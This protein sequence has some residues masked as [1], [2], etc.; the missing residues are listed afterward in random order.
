MVE[1]SL[2]FKR[3]NLLIRKPLT[4]GFIYLFLYNFLSAAQG[5]LLSEIFQKKS[6][7]SF[8]F[9]NFLLLSLL[10]WCVFVFKK[11]NDLR[12]IRL[13]DIGLLNII[14]VISW[15]SY[16]LALKYIEPAIEA[17][18]GCAIPAIVTFVILL[19][20]QPAA[21]QKREEVF[22]VIGLATGS[23]ILVIT[24]LSGKSGKVNGAGILVYLGL[25]MAFLCGTSVALYSLFSKKLS[26]R[27]ISANTILCL[28]F[29]LLLIIACWFSPTGEISDI[30]ISNELLVYS[31]L[32]ISGT[33]LPLYFLQLG[34]PKLEPLQVSFMMG[35]LPAFFFINQ[36]LLSGIAFSWLTLFGV[37]TVVSSLLFVP[38]FHI[39]RRN[40]H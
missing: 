23:L 12:L 24:A 17:A 33:I 27:G 26:Q 7:F 19:F 4:V 34:I 6:V 1:A 20:K 2:K 30:F 22:P 31:L 38:I 40:Q 11:E 18:I 13:G 39:Y 32:A 16:Y 5:V 15:V 3:F 35:W 29:P 37:I 10:S 21:Q 36:L 28:R 25:I 14:T 8:L 9:F